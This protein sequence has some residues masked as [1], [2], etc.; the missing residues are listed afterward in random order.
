MKFIP[1][2]AILKRTDDIVSSDID[3]ETVMMSIENGK[4]YGMDTIGSRVWELLEVPITL[5]DM[6]TRLSEEYEIDENT[7]SNDV[8]SFLEKL[9]EEK[10]ISVMDE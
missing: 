5:T 3:G 1:A 4:Y 2:N 10:L 7:C 9:K 6:C 8:T